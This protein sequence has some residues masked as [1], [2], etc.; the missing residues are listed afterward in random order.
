MTETYILNLL[1]P[2]KIAA[3]G[4][5]L[6]N[7]KTD[8]CHIPGRAYPT[9]R[10]T[11]E[12][13]KEIAAYYFNR[14]SRD[15]KNAVEVDGVDPTDILCMSRDYPWNDFLTVIQYGGVLGMTEL[16][17]YKFCYGDKGLQ[18]EDDLERVTSI[19][20]IEKNIFDLTSVKLKK[21][22]PFNRV[23]TERYWVPDESG[24]YL[25]EE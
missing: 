8:F 3:H 25:L 22:D 14:I 23:V 21:V 20:D 24:E 10:Q 12:L 9:E 18:T 17:V 7:L 11:K 15:Y 1:N 13:V 19:Y 16:T 5:A 2:D 6:D 4:L